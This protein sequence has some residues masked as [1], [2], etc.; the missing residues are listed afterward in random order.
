MTD[1]PFKRSEL[2]KDFSQLHKLIYSWPKQGKST[3]CSKMKVGDKEPFFIST[4]DGLHALNVYNQRVRNWEQYIA[5]KDFILKSADKMREKFS[6]IVID[7]VSDLDDMCTDYICRSKKVSALADLEW[8]KGWTLQANE[9]QHQVF[10]L[11]DILP[12]TFITHTKE[13]ELMYNGE[14][15][16]T[17]APTLSQRCLDGINGKVDIIAWIVPA[18]NK[19]ENPVLTMKPGNMAVCGSR[20]SFMCR[21]FVLSFA[22]MDLSYKAINDFYSANLTKGE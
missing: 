6:C 15:I 16:K 3:L 4:E 18:N 12:V 19:N 10:P 22:D 7:L 17:Q 21:D 5:L 1:L 13:K 14:R 11:L 2:K 20:Y 8:G 9:F